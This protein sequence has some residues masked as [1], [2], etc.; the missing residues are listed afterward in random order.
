ML[1]L[2]NNQP[3]SMNVVF[4]T[5]LVYIV[6]LLHCVISDTQCPADGIVGCRCRPSDD[7]IYCSKVYTGDDVP[8]FRRS[9]HVY[10]VVSYR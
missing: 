3:P 8:I 9:N 1:Y 2:F 6:I 7:N 5:T 10:P 4:L